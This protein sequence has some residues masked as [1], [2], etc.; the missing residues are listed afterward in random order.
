[1]N[2]MQKHDLPITTT[3]TKY[4]LHGAISILNPEGVQHSFSLLMKSK[5]NTKL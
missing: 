1:M 5:I 3:E 2:E 4:G